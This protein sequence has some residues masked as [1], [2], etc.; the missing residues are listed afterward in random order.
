MDGESVPFSESLYPTG[1]V[2]DW[3][4]EVERVMRQSILESIR[5]SVED[6]P[7]VMAYWTGF[8]FKILVLSVSHVM[9]E[10]K[11]DTL[12]LDLGTISVFTSII[13]RLLL[14][15]HRSCSR[16]LKLTQKRASKIQYPL[17]TKTNADPLELFSDCQN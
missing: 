3:L 4:L 1:N 16:R 11:S 5:L 17:N 2:E 7:K 6:Y 14:K 13:Q 9:L 8:Y 10:F 15:A 12:N